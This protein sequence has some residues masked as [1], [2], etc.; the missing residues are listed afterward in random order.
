M[1]RWLSADEQRHW[2]SWLAASILLNDRLS[3]D[4][5][6]QHGLTIADYEI[7]VHLSEAPDRRLRMS[8][9]AERALSSRSRLSHQIDRMRTAGLVDRESCADDRRGAFAVL[10]ERGWE[11][12]VAAAP[13]HVESVRRH[14]IDVLTP[15]EFAALGRAC[16]QVADGLGGGNRGPAAE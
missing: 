13:D 3:R 5:Q 10:T 9:L 6:E 15:E 2:R 14:L 1:T 12:L 16:A 7:L 11:V 8:E 4:L